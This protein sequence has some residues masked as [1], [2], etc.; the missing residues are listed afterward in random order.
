MMYSMTFV[1]VLM[2]FLIL[3]VLGA[4]VAV[5]VYGARR[6]RDDHR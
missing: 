5:R 2:A 3:A 4:L 1:M 6:V